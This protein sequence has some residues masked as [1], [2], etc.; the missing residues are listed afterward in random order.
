MGKMIT[1]SFCAY[2]NKKDLFVVNFSLDGW[3]VQKKYYIVK[4]TKSTI[5]CLT[6]TTTKCNT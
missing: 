2:L 1:H 4:L 5:L 3:L 6:R